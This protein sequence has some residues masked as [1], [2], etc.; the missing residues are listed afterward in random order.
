[1]TGLASRVKGSKT[2]V[3]HSYTWLLDVQ[4]LLLVE[5]RQFAGVCVGIQPVFV[6]FALKITS[7]GKATPAPLTHLIAVIHSCRPPITF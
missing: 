5:N 6:C 2:G 1:M 7:G 3:N 4:P